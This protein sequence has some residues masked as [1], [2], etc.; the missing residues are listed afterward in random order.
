MSMPNMPFFLEDQ[1]S[2]VDSLWKTFA[3]PE[4]AC[5]ISMKVDDNSSWKK[6]INSK[7]YAFIKEILNDH[8][9]HFDILRKF[10]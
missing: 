8:T 7:V 5:K 10:E 6:T 1:L 3:L 4:S 9:Q 2:K